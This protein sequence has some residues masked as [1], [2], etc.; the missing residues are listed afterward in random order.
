VKPFILIVILN[1]TINEGITDRAMEENRDIPEAANSGTEAIPSESIMASIKKWFHGRPE[2]DRELIDS[3]VETVEPKIKGVRGYQKRLLRPLQLCQEH[4]RKI[5]AGIPGPIYLKHSDYY[6]DPLINAAF[7]GSEKIEDL[8]SKSETLSLSAENPT[9]PK[10]VAL[11]TMTRTDR[12]IF[13]R[14]KHGDLIVGDERLKSIT[15]SDHKIVGLAETVESS[16]KLLEKYILEIII[17]SASHQLAARRADIGELRQRRE[18]LQAMWEMFGG[19]SHA[20]KFSGLDHPDEDEK[21]EKVESML[22]KTEKELSTAIKSYDTPKDWLIFLEHYLSAPEKI[23]AVSL[24]SLRL[25]WRNVI[26]EDPDDKANTITFAQC[27]IAEEVTRDAVFIAYTIKPENQ[28]A[29][30][31]PNNPPQPS[32]S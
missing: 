7:A 26:T 14:S 29:Q 24:V 9:G 11:L 5:V 32:D 12:T 22:E 31:N 28:A 10:R 13:G 8:L 6:A 3:I 15:F 16:H 2:A 30:V 4:C 20:D 19:T 23:L 25:D 21:L 27:S 17:D 18:K 1:Y